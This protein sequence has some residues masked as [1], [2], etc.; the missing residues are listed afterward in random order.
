MHGLEII[1]ARLSSQSLAESDGAGCGCDG[2]R[3]KERRGDDAVGGEE[4]VFVQGE[5]Q[6]VFG[7]GD[8]CAV[9]VGG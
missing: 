6:L 5:L 3:R 1:H 8:V 9:E 4:E 2:F 7:Y